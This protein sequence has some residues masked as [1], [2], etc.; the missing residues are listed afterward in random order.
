MSVFCEY[1]VLSG[2]YLYIGPIPRPEDSC[3]VSFVRVR[4]PRHI[5]RGGGVAP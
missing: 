1:L 4:T 2:R 3:R 5:V